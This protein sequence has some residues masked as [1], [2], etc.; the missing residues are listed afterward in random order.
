MA[1]IRKREKLPGGQAE[2]MRER[3]Q[4]EEARPDTPI[5]DQTL[6][7]LIPK[8]IKNMGMEKE[9][10]VKEIFEKWPELVGNDVAQH[11]RPGNYERKQ[12]LVYVN[13]SIWLMELE[14]NGKKQMLQNLQEMYG[15]DNIKG[16]RFQL[17]PD[18]TI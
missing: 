16:I 8:V 10:W 17:D 9:Y 15:A 2:V 18:G 5:Q 7:D 4:L 11:T 6:E 14:R 13:H 12:L 1:R 3:F